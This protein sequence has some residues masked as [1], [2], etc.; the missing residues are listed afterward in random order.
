MDEDLHIGHRA[1]MYNKFLSSGEYMPDHELLEILLYPLIPRLDTNPIA[2]RLLYTFGDL[3]SV[4]SASP[5]KLMTVK[6]IGKKTASELA[7]IGKVFE[8]AYVKAPKKD[9]NSWSSFYNV[10]NEVVKQFENINEEQFLLILLNGKFKPIS[11]IK[12]E[13]GKDAFVQ[14]DGTDITRTITAHSPKHVIIAHNHPSGNCNPSEIDDINTTKMVVICDVLNVDFSD[15]VIVSKSDVYSYHNS[16][17]LD[18][19]KKLANIKNLGKIDE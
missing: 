17:R 3:K 6:G 9:E 12:F 11:K 18:K 14:A 19:I 15:H 10:K 13:N 5:E 16:G 2:H 1:R 8:L 7:V 4:L